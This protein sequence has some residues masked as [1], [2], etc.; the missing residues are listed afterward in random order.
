MKQNEDF[1][2]TDDAELLNSYRGLVSEL[3]SV[4]KGLIAAHHPD[5]VPPNGSEVTDEERQ[6]VMDWAMALIKQ[7]EGDKFDESLFKRR[8]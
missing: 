5:F 8:D 3:V 2:S 6:I 7:I 4:V 1:F